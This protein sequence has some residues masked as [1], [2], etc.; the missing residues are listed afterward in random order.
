MASINNVVLVGRLVKDVEVVKSKDTFI[1]NT[2][3]AIDGLK[4]DAP[5]SFVNLVLFD[6]NATNAAD[7]C[8][9][10]DRVGVIGRLQSRTY[11]G[12]D[13]SKK[14]ITEVVVTSIQFLESKKTEEDDEEEEEPSKT[15]KYT[16]KKK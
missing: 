10:G 14:Y 12:K 8:S 15:S 3:I 4:K 9:K 11:E 1:G 16:P 2:S 13:G 6:K 7:Y 5:A